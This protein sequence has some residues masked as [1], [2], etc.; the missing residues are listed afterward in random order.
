ML[1]LQGLGLIKLGQFK[2]WNKKALSTSWSNPSGQPI[3]A[4]KRKLLH[5]TKFYCPQ[6][7]TFYLV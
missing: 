5:V 4:E 7:K 2:V 3:R 6:M 1:Y